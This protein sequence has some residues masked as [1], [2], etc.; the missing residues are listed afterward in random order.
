MSNYIQV[1][2]GTPSVLKRIMAKHPERKLYLYKSTSQRDFQ[3]VDFSNRKSVFNSPIK[4]QILES[5]INNCRKNFINYQFMNLNRK[6]IKVLRSWLKLTE[7][8]SQSVRMNQ[9]YWLTSSDHL[10]QII[11]TGWDQNSSYKKWKHDFRLKF[12]KLDP[13]NSFYE[14]DYYLL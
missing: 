3:L 13:S 14:R 4:Y 10:W 1:T 12:N 5:K 11:L 7:Q 8:N 2:F 9:I 6:Q